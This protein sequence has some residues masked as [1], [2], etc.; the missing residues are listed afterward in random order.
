MATKRSWKGWG[1]R[2]SVGFHGHSHFL[3]L[4]LKIHTFCTLTLK[5]SHFLHVS[6]CECLGWLLGA[7]FSSASRGE[8]TSFWTGTTVITT[9]GG[10]RRSS[11]LRTPGVRE[12]SRF[13]P[14]TV[15]F[16][17]TRQLQ[18]AAQ[19]EQTR[20]SAAERGPFDITGRGGCGKEED[21]STV[22]GPAA[23]V[24]RGDGKN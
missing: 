14:P 6:P 18:T 8:V 22:W 13:I 4:F 9:V 16:I 15:R 20:A 24:G 5:I 2:F 10:S 1:S 17:S 19:N 12:C 11:G 3:H 23:G 21:G 7:S